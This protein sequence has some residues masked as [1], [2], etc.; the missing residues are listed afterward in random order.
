MNIKKEQKICTLYVFGMVASVH[1]SY[2][3]L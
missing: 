3:D 1:T 2:K